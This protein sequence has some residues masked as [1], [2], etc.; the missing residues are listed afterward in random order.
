MDDDNK[1]NNCQDCSDGDCILGTGKEC[2]ENSDC[3]PE[4]HCMIYTESCTCYCDSGSCW[5]MDTVPSVEEECDDCDGFLTGCTDL[6]EIT[7]SYTRWIASYSYGYCKDPTKTVT[8]GYLYG[9]DEDWD[10]GKIVACAGGVPLCGHLCR[11]APWWACVLCFV[12]E[13][14]VCV[15][16]GVCSLVEDCVLGDEFTSVERDV[17]DNNGDRGNYQECGIHS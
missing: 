17:V 13:G 12:V 10:V 16:D 15:S 4:E 1:C 5:K 8:I 14:A 3:E 6:V 11:T 9:C 2:D 7:D